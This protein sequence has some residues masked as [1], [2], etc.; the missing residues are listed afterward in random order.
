MGYSRNFGFRSFENIIRDARFRVPADAPD[1]GYMIGTAVAVDDATPGYFRV[2]G[3]GEAPT[4]LCGIVLYEHILGAQGV[5]PN[6]T[7]TSDPPFNMAPAGRYAQMIHGPGT[8]V[9]FRNT[10]D[11]PMYDGRMLAGIDIVD[12]GDDGAGNPA[13]AVGDFLTPA[14][15]GTWAIGALATG[16]LVVE[17]FNPTSG[18]VEARFRF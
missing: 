10:A 17:Q 11:R 12:L 3:A 16:W 18:L 7:T 14:A 8:K 1:G 5:D 6:L 13:L 15:D 4:P 2:A 9:W